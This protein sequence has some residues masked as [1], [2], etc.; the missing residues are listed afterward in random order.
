MWYKSIQRHVRLRLGLIV[1][2]LYS[3]S[4]FFFFSSSKDRTHTGLKGGKQGNESKV[5]FGTKYKNIFEL[6]TGFQ[7]QF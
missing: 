7:G 6:E 1:F 4:L 3:E 2:K 5:G